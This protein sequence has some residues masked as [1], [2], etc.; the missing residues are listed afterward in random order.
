MVPL[1]QPS[2][3]VEAASTNVVNNQSVIDLPQQAIKDLL[4]KE[5]SLTIEILSASLSD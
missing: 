4:P 3:P 2:N 1:R 5:V